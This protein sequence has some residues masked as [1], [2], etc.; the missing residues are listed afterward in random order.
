[1]RAHRTIRCMRTFATIGALGL[2]LGGC[3]KSEE[4]GSTTQKTASAGQQ[5]AAPTQ[6]PLTSGTTSGAMGSSTPTGSGSGAAPA[7]G[8]AAVPASEALASDS[9]LLEGGTRI[10]ADGVSFVVPSGWQRETVSSSMRAAQYRIPAK[11]EGE[12]ATFVVFR[13]IGGSPEE[14]IQRWIGQLTDKPAAPER[15]TVDIGHGLTVHTVKMTGTYTV[16]TMM[17]GSGNPE[18]DTMFL[19]AVITGGP[20]DLPVF[21]RVTG[22]RTSVEPRLEEWNAVLA[23]VL[24]AS[25]VQ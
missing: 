11:G 25:H 21:F 23:S 13:G 20:S 3:G 15:A 4:G 14:N 24:P 9:S 12:E 17:G 7:P 18:P 8:S 6:N 19:G 1:M 10:D 22:P 2:F 5:H 16:G